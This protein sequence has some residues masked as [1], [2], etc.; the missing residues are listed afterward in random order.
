MRMRQRVRVGIVPPG[1]AGRRR[2]RVRRRC[3]CGC[4]FGCECGCGC[5]CGCG[6]GRG[7][8]CGS[9]CRCGGGGSGA[10]VR[11]LASRSYAW[12]KSVGRRRALYCRR[13]S[14]VSPTERKMSSCGGGGGMEKGID[15]GCGYCTQWVGVRVGP[16]RVV[17][18]VCECAVCAGPMSAYD[19][20]LGRA[21]PQPE[22]R[23]EDAR[24]LQ[25]AALEGPKARQRRAGHRRR[26]ESAPSD[27]FWRPSVCL[28]NKPLTVR[29]AASGFRMTMR[30]DRL[31]LGEVA[32]PFAASLV[33][34]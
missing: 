5:T 12:R 33:H 27:R 26:G 21:R 7:G 18:S 14:R 22:P 32:R 24:R 9:G 6:C 8:R 28:L 3:G 16:L 30:L 10:A 13:W 29:N 25:V 19:A 20:L 11:A 1:R 2:K 4:G 23:L 34:L 15:G 17:G 31:G